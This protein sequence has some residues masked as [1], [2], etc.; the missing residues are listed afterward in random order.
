MSLGSEFDG[1]KRWKSLEERGISSEALEGLTIES[2]ECLERLTNYDSHSVHDFGIVKRAAVLVVLF[3]RE[4]DEKLHVLL[5]TRAKTLR[6]HPSQT[7]LP[8]GKVDPDDRDATHT[9]RREAFEEVNLPL[10]HPSIHNL[11][12]LEPVMTI[13][14]LNAHM[15]NHIIVIPVVCFLSDVSLLEHLLP[16]PDEVDAIFTHPLKGCL[17]GTVE[18]KD[19]EGLAEKGSEWWPYE[20]EF[21]S[22]EDR[23]GTTGGYRM[24]RFRTKRTPIKGLTSDVLVHAASV[25]YGSPPAFGQFA[26]NQPPFS[27]AISNVVLELPGVIDQSITSSVPGEPPRVLEWGGTE[28][29]TRI[30]SREQYELV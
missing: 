12:V 29:G 13:L 9:A 17:T 22:I 23:I 11:T 30:I 14:P 21:H 26:P 19:L 5:T 24:H 27:S 16:S 7:A 4:A 2:R 6:R 15:K 25:A 28:K 10:E 8:G 18:G 1:S 3:Q 20:E